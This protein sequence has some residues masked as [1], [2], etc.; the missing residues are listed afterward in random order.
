M[1]QDVKTQVLLRQ[2]TPH[3]GII[4]AAREDRCDLIA[5]PTRGLKGWKYYMLGSTAEKVVRHALCPV[6]TFNR[7]LTSGDRGQ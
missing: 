4:N 7:Y 2:G 3:R 1:P 5:L 6:L